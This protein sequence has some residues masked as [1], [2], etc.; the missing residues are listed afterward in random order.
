MSQITMKTSKERDTC[1]SRGRNINVFALAG[2]EIKKKGGQGPTGLRP[3]KLRRERFDTNYI[4]TRHYKY[5]LNN[6]HVAYFVAFFI[7]CH[8]GKGE[9]MYGRGIVST[10]L[11][12]QKRIFT[13]ISSS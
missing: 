2:R 9:V 6:R 5:L 3:V 12:A 8:S 10:A 13:K 1:G 7:V 4:V 11:Q